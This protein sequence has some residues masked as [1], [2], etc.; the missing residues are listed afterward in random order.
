MPTS[1]LINYCL[2]KTVLNLTILY[3]KIGAEEG[4]DQEVRIRLQT[5]KF[6]HGFS[7]KS[8]VWGGS[9]SATREFSTKVQLKEKC[10]EMFDPKV[11]C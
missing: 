9:G 3:S 5:K 4:A 1:Y 6:S 7:Q 2:V 11:S 10:Y 8:S